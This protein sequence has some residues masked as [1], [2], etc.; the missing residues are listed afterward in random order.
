LA[1]VE[2][3]DKYGYI[4]QAG[5]WVIKP[6]FDWTDDF[7]DNGLAKVNLNGKYGYINQAG[8]WVIKPQFKDAYSFSDN[9][10]ARVKVNGK[11]G[12]I[13]NQGQWILKPLF[14]NVDFV[15][16]LIRVEF[17]ASEGYTDLKGQYLTFS[18]DEVN[19]ANSNY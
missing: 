2:L 4:N 12:V 14:C 16:D 10:L 3:N 15:R 5:D 9:G 13:N 8:D 7:S 11:V 18:E 19:N 1:S 6:Q 17:G